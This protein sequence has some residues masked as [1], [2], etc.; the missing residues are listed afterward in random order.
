MYVCS[1]ANVCKTFY[2]RPFSSVLPQA[3]PPDLVLKI[4]QYASREYLLVS[5]GRQN[6]QKYL[7]VSAGRHSD[8]FLNVIIFN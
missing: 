4:R 3:M 5:A 7:L 1:S 2:G 6:K 8:S